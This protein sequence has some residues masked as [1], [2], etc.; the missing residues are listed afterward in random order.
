M[1]NFKFLVLLFIIP[2]LTF[3][4]IGCSDSSSNDD[5]DEYNVLLEYLE[6]DG[7]DFINTTYTGAIKSAE[8][9]KT[10]LGTSGQ[11]LID[12]RS[13]DAYAS[14]H[15]EG[16]VRVDWADLITHVEGITSNP[17][18]IIIICYSGQSAAYG[19]SLLRLLGHDNV[20]SMK[21]G[22]TSWNSDFD[23]WTTNCS[24]ARVTQFETT[25]NPKG[26]VVDPP[27]LDTGEKEA[28]AILRKRVET[29]LEAGFSAGAVSHTDVFNDLDGYYINN[30]WPTDQYLNPGHIPGAINYVPKQDLKSENYL[31]TLPAD[32]KIVSYCYT[33][34]GSAFL[35]AYLR[36]LGYD[37]YSLKFGANG[38]IH[39]SM[40]ASKFGAAAM[41]EYDYVTGN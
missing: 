23:S 4:F 40:P 32:K 17:T 14:G 22:M 15:V 28:V 20:Y 36:V 21:F 33:G 9:V 13:A 8:Q 41:M 6:S 38:M 34:Q 26:P 16:A 19:A 2:A 29:V 7:G 11:Y 37:A 12:I 39:D 18:E 24:N 31:N 3:T 5:V 1:R 27:V 25:N 30:Y 10:N 35:T